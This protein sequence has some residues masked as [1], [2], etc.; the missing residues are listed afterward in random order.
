MPPTSIVCIPDISKE[1]SG[2]G[3]V[4]IDFLLPNGVFLQLD[5]DFHK[6][7]DLLKQA[8][9][10]SAQNYPLFGRL[11]GKD[12]YCFEFLNRNG[13][14]EE[15]TDESF[16]LSDLR[17]IGKFLRL[18]ER[19]DIEGYQT[20]DR[21]ISSLLGSKLTMEMY[22][23]PRVEVDD[24]RKR[25]YSFALSKV[26][27][28]DFHALFENRYPLQL[29]STDHLPDELKKKLNNGYLVVSVRIQEAN[30]QKFLIQSHVTEFAL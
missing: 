16:R 19:Q 15:V 25:M 4:Q 8:L 13:E 27:Q 1:V 10:E 9:W 30:K 29:R 3:R 18:Q 14:K 6:P 20:I 5:V 28:N 22:A 2:D 26:P 23:M 24:F 17:P 7:L 11:K 12:Y 21:Q